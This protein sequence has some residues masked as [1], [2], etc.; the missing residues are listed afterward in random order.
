MSALPA[1]FAD[2]VRRTECLVWIG[3][4]NSK[5]YG[6]VSVGAG[7]SALAHRLAFEAEY[8]PIPEG[9]VI[10]HLCRVRNCVNPMH[11]EA[12][13]TGENNRRGR[14]AKTLTVG[15]ICING[16][17]LSEGDIYTAPRGTTECRHCRRSNAHRVNGD[18][19]GRKTAQRRA[20]QVARDLDAT[21][22]AA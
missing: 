20:T 13:T 8:G 5:G 21:D 6:L 15:D 17:Q 16:H 12:V 11:L 7:K 4:T 18:R 9:M 1:A 2:K 10:D 14:A 19:P 3:S 22:G